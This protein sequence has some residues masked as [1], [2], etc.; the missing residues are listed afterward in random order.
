MGGHGLQVNLPKWPHWQLEDTLMKPATWLIVPDHSTGNIWPISP[1]LPL[2]VFTFLP[3]AQNVA[4]VI[5]LAGDGNGKVCMVSQFGLSPSCYSLN[6]PGGV[7]GP[8]VNPGIQSAFCQNGIAFIDGGILG[9]S[10]SGSIQAYDTDFNPLGGSYPVLPAQ[11][12]L[13]QGLAVDTAKGILYAACQNTL[14]YLDLSTPTAWQGVPLN[15]RW[16]LAAQP[17]PLTL[18]VDSQ[19]GDVYI[20]YLPDAGQPSEANVGVFNLFSPGNVASLNPSNFSPG[21][22]LAVAQV[23]GSVSVFASVMSGGSCVIECYTAAQNQ[24]VS[25]PGNPPSLQQVKALA[26]TETAVTWQKLILVE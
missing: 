2:N 10:P 5:A 18:A 26:V 15:S 22:G 23:N 16:G 25:V 21:G 20:L 9:M 8:I 11:P 17:F 13:Q 6:Y 7:L 1:V 19:S 3:I 24:F 4:G 12:S 14:Y